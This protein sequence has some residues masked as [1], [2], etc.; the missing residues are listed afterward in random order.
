MEDTVGTLKDFIG[1]R[2]ELFSDEMTLMIHQ[3]HPYPLADS[4]QLSRLYVEHRH[5]TLLIHEGGE[6]RYGRTLENPE[7][8]SERYV[9][10]RYIGNVNGQVVLD[11]RYLSPSCLPRIRY[12]LYQTR[13]VSQLWLLG[14]HPNVMDILYAIAEDVL[15]LMNLQTIIIQNPAYNGYHIPYKSTSRH[16]VGPSH[17]Q[18]DGLSYLYQ[19]LLLDQYRDATEEVEIWVD[20]GLLPGNS[21][22]Y[23]YRRDTT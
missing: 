17:L 1:E 10:E 3:S 18:Q 15:C 16:F 23:R 14:T 6:I 9:P 7:E 8:S 13:T 11:F 20:G 4:L 21:V 2:Y 12:W 19:H 22:R 5:L